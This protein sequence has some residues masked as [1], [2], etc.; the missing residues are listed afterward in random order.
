ME[1]VLTKQFAL[2]YLMNTCSIMSGFFIINNF[3][4]YD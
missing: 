2:L 3:K 4:S 1:M